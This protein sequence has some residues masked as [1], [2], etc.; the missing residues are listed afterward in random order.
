[1]TTVVVLGT[2]KEIKITTSIAREAAMTRT[3]IQRKAAE[4]ENQLYRVQFKDDKM[5]GS[6]VDE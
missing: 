1:M 6:F 5:N 3:Q 4:T 2:D